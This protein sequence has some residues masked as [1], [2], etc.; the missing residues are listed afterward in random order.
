MLI[1]KNSETERAAR[2]FLHDFEHQTGKTIEVTDVDS[3][4]GAQMAGLYDTVSFPAILALSDDGSVLQQW[5]GEVL[6]RISEVSY[7][8]V[9]R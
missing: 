2:E 1:R 6:P 7:Y 5:Q 9:N 8:A 3:P 4:E